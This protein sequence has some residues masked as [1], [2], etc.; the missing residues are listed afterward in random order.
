MIWFM[1]LQIVSMLVDLVRLGHKSEGEKDLEILLLRRQLAILE[2]KSRPPVRLSRSEKLTL[3]V[4]AVRLKAK[5]GRTIKQLGEAFRIVKP[6]T[7]FRWHNELV[8]RKWTYRQQNRG[9]RPRTDREI[10]RLG[11]SAGR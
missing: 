4:L 2:R 7:V 10:E 9:G 1:V 6:R 8:R 5:T 3:V 11:S